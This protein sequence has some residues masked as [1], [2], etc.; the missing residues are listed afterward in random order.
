MFP[1]TLFTCIRT[2][3]FTH[4]IEHKWAK[5]IQI[6]ESI[7][8]VPCVGTYIEANFK[9]PM[10]RFTSSVI[11]PY[12]TI[13]QVT[14]TQFTFQ[15]RN[16][17]QNTA[18][19]TF[20]DRIEPTVYYAVFCFETSTG[21]SYPEK[22]CTIH[23]KTAREVSDLYRNNLSEKNFN[24]CLFTYYPTHSENIFNGSPEINDILL[25]D[26]VFHRVYSIYPN[27]FRFL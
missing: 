22:P 17:I 6:E 16:K 18:H 5:E 2:P 14:S 9:P 3:Y 23:L 1:R 20:E 4:Y 15:D 7:K 8:P 13:H 26:S 10:L 12:V 21:R 19:L 25:Y 27:M 11:Y 24:H